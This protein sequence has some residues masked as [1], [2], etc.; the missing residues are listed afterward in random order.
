[1]DII[2]TTRELQERADRDRSRGQTIALVPTMGA[3]HPGHLSLIA[4]ARE[5]ADQVWVSIFVNSAQ[6]NVSE[7]FEGYPRTF[8]ADAESCRAAGVDVVFAP[9][10]DQL[11]PEGAETWVEVGKIAEPLCG[12]SRPGKNLRR[13]RFTTTPASRPSPSGNRRRPSGNPTNRSTG[14]V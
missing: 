2:R 11:Y 8:E 6:F 12:A 5:C 14:T 10:P 1:M 9:S 13:Y 7:D 3:L 4:S